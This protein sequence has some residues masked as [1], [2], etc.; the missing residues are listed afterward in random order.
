MRP[1]LGAS[2]SDYSEWNIDEKWCSQEWTSDEMLEAR[3]ELFTQ[4]TDRLVI[5]DDDMDSNTATESDL[6]LKSRLFLHRVNDRLRKILDQS[7]KD[8]MQDSDK[9]SLIWRMFMSST[10]EGSVFMGKSYSNILHSVKDTGSNLTLKQKFD[11]FEKLIVGQSAEIFEVTP[12]NWEDSSWKHLSLVNDEEVISLSHAKVYVS[13]DFVLCPGKV[14]QNPTSNSAW[15]EKL[16]C[17]KSSSQY[18]TLDTIDGEPIEFEWNI[19]PRFTTLQ[20]CNKVEEFMS[21]MSDPSQ[22]KG[23]IIIMSMFNDILWRSEVDERECDANA[24]LVSIHAKR[25]P[26]GRW[27]FL[28]PGSEKKWCSTHESKPQG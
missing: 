2:S 21:K 7:L 25:F 13:S 16:S 5:D 27:S 17:F 1:V 18:R 22:F 12:I 11:M 28:G 20:L 15:E 23:R 10:L 9:H 19:F 4:H 6:S 26:A 24:D 14:S 3:T 8:A